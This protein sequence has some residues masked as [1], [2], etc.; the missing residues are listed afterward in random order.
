MWASI[1]TSLFC[2]VTCASS[3][4]LKNEI[5]MESN[6]FSANRAAV[7][8]RFQL[9]GRR[10]AN[11]NAQIVVSQIQFLN[12]F[13]YQS[14]TCGGTP[15]ETQSYQF[16]TCL[17]STS[18]NGPFAAGNITLTDTTISWVDYFYSNSDCTGF[19]TSVH[20]GPFPLACN[21]DFGMPGLFSATSSRPAYPSD[22][23]ALVTYPDSSQCESLTSG[24][25]YQFYAYDTCIGNANPY[26]PSSAYVAYMYTSCDSSMST[27]STNFYQTSTCSGNIYSVQQSYLSCP[28]YNDDL[29]E[30]G[31]LALQCVSGSND[32]GTG[33]DDYNTDD[34]GTANNNL[35][36]GDIAGIVIGVTFGVIITSLLCYAHVFKKANSQPMSSS[37]ELA[38]RA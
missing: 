17:T 37:T 38:N 16:G 20:Y 8:A 12:F 14:S 26:K 1:I 10:P 34:D 9:G 31:N 19:L 30:T 25:H 3:L 15:F 29:F 2:V 13:F 33:D 7:E 6:V 28:A 22:G 11:Q 32:D 24:N 18:T 21:S 23:V 36:R 27:V 4:A 35:T 5:E